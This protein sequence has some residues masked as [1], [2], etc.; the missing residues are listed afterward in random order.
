M[1]SND[2]VSLRAVEPDDLDM[3]FMLENDPDAAENSFGNAPASR[4]MLW[5]YIEN[6]SADIH[7]AGELRLVIVDNQSGTAAGTID[8]SDYNNRDRHG[9]VGIALLPQWRNRGLGTAALRLLCRYAAETV[10]AHCLAAQIASDN[11]ASRHIFASAGF[12]TCGSLRSWIRRGP[13]Y[14]DALL[15]QILFP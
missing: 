11:E 10:G 5:Q 9:F 13:H 7:S 2:K 6:Y 1:I 14:A 15:Y 8:I 3:L 4:H 12:R